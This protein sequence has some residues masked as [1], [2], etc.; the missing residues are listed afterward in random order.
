MATKR[1]HQR[2]DPVPQTS[3]HGRSLE[4]GRRLSGR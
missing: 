3:A 4:I 1:P 2:L